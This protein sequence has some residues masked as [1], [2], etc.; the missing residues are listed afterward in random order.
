MA[1][2]F[3]STR[4]IQKEL[5]KIQASKDDEAVQERIFSVLDR[6]AS[7]QAGTGET[8]ALY[9]EAIKTAIS[10]L[11]NFPQQAQDL[12]KHLERYR[13]SLTGERESAVYEVL[14]LFGEMVLQLK[15]LD[16]ARTALKLC[17]ESRTI[18]APA[19]TKA[20]ELFLEAGFT[21]I[22]DI[23]VV[24]ALR[25]KL[26]PELERQAL[27]TLETACLIDETTA[28]DRLKQLI[29]WNQLIGKRI[30]TLGWPPRNLAL[31]L[32][33]ME[34]KPDLEL[35]ASYLDQALKIYPADRLASEALILLALRNDNPVLAMYGLRTFGPALSPALRELYERLADELPAVLKTRDVV[36]RPLLDVNR[37]LTDLNQGLVARMLGST[38]VLASAR[39]HRLSG[40]AQEALDGFTAYYLDH[41]KDAVG[42]YELI[43]SYLET[44]NNEQAQA[45]MAEAHD[46]LTLLPV[47]LFC[48]WLEISPDS[49]ASINE[50]DLA[51]E[52]NLEPPENLMLWLVQAKILCLKR[53]ENSCPRLPRV[54][55]FNRVSIAEE[56]GR[57]QW[58]VT[59]AT[60]NREQWSL[61]QSRPEFLTL[62]LPEQR[63]AGLIAK[64][65]FEADL[66]LTTRISQVQAF[67]QQF[68]FHEAAKQLLE[69]L[70]W[71]VKEEESG[72]PERDQS[73]GDKAVLPDLALQDAVKA[74]L[75][76]DPEAYSRWLALVE[77]R[78]RD[79]KPYLY[80][81]LLA[82]RAYRE[83][84]PLPA[85]T[86]TDSG[87]LDTG[88]LADRYFQKA[89]ALLNVGDSKHLYLLKQ[90]VLLAR[91]RFGSGN[92]ELLASALVSALTGLQRPPPL[93]ILH[94]LLSVSKLELL[95]HRNEGFSELLS[96]LA[97]SGT[98][99]PILEKALYQGLVS[100]LFLDLDKTRTRAQKILSVAPDLKTEVFD[101][102]GTLRYLRSLAE[103]KSSQCHLPTIYRRITSYL[104][105]SSDNPLLNLL[106]TRVAVALERW[107]DLDRYLPYIDASEPAIQ[108]LQAF[109]AYLQGNLDAS[110]ASLTE[111]Q[112]SGGALADR[113]AALQAI[114]KLISKEPQ[115]AR[116]PFTALFQ[117]GNNLAMQAIPPEVLPVFMAAFGIGQSA[118]KNLP[119]DRRQLLREQTAIAAAQ[120]GDH[121]EA[122]KIFEEIITSGDPETTILYC[123]YLLH[124][125]VR[126]LKADRGL[127]INLLTTA[128]NYLQRSSAEQ[129]T[130]EAAGLASKINV[131]LNHFQA[132]A[133]Y[134]ALCRHIP[135]GVSLGAEHFLMFKG[136][137]SQFPKLPMVVAVASDCEGANPE[138]YLHQALR[139][140]ASEPELLLALALFYR[141]TVVRLESQ[142]TEAVI[143]QLWVLA[144][145]L[146]LAFVYY[147]DQL[148]SQRSDTVLL[149]S[150]DS[151]TNLVAIEI[152]LED[153][154]E[155]LL[156]HLAANRLAAASLHLKILLAI[157]NLEQVEQHFVPLFLLVSTGAQPLELAHVLAGTGARLVSKLRSDFYKRLEQG[158]ALIGTE[159]LPD[160]APEAK[161]YQEL[162]WYISAIADDSRLRYRALE[163]CNILRQHY[164]KPESLATLRILN[165]LARNLFDP[166]ADPEKVFRNPDNRALSNQIMW[167]AIT[168]ASW[169]KQLQLMDAALNYDYQNLRARVLIEEKLEEEPEALKLF[170]KLLELDCHEVAIILLRLKGRE[171]YS[172][173]E[174]DRILLELLDQ[175]IDELLTAQEWRAAL[176][177]LELAL[178][179][180]PANAN[181]LEQTITVRTHARDQ[182]IL[183]DIRNAEVEA[184]NNRRRRAVPLLARVPKYFSHY[185]QVSKLLA[186]IEQSGIEGWRS[187]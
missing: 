18:A 167:L 174:Y 134:D 25:G 160:S 49:I 38:G 175:R 146:W 97:Y 21:S 163:L 178:E 8:L 54:K 103:F 185:E 144:D 44:G 13:A 124:R 148:Q 182:L 145:T 88:E 76:K 98:S 110:Y 159:E 91:Q 62:P 115:S 138:A 162:E 153:H 100:V 34:A 137:L 151:E 84:L 51:A 39:L 94:I 156:Q 129:V 65:V 12:F 85:L 106:A 131:L 55:K 46:K 117:T 56:F 41:D 154:S 180:D 102:I 48:L 70:T 95:D 123:R 81:G 171:F 19:R 26:L 166:E 114:L 20:L 73:P 126:E 15:N 108:L 113:A 2:F 155:L 64:F 53:E 128:R 141:N 181:R 77:C 99:A 30:V 135:K 52:F 139:Q 132:D 105:T 121:G 86:P 47:E 4:K 122:C 187:R 42:Y 89:E 118:A 9:H 37:L 32:L 17:L 78:P 74:Y 11:P 71:R 176:P 179:L 150:W 36:L 183:L 24:L 177:H 92:S 147:V 168:E 170:S 161:T 173:V 57:I 67:L 58:R 50:N 7:G 60:P 31:G 127:A 63:Y 69:L 28:P 5:R 59:L 125:A 116:E 140:F 93:S 87:N 40:A 66:P 169:D 82:A 45:L 172:K 1:G 29:S 79:P 142:A 133:I 119:T 109:R 22:D 96:Y 130:E 120:R 90:R 158:L 80:L 23:Q 152:W 16:L 3:S 104:S 111:L 143:E 136:L 184:A 6:I 75:A 14:V 149:R 165:G 68:P 27:A 43:R 33:F 61:L 83:G 164:G 10:V 107:S 157:G 186:E 112:T 101:A 35:A 72:A